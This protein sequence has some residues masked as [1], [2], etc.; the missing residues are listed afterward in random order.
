MLYD[1]GA[2]EVHSLAAPP[3]GPLYA[4]TLATAAPAMDL[5]QILVSQVAQVRSGGLEGQGDAGEAMMQ[6][7]GAAEESA[8]AATNSQLLRIDADGYGFNVWPLERDEV[9]SLLA[10]AGGEVL[11]GT[12]REGRLYR[13]NGAGDISLLLKFEA[14]Q[15]SA[16]HRTAKQRLVLAT[17]N[18]G[19]CYSLDGRGDMGR[20]ESET[21]NAATVA[22]WGALSWRG[23]GKIAFQTRSG[24]TQKPEGTWS[25]WQ[26]L[27]SES[28]VWR[29]ASPAARFLQWRCDLKNGGTQPALEEVTLSYLQKNLPPEIVEL[30]ILPAGDFFDASQDHLSAG[31]GIVEAPS[32]PKRD[33]KKGY[34]TAA[35]QFNDPNRDELLFSLWYRRKADIHWRRLATSLAHTVY[36]W[37]TTQMADGEYQIKV[38]ASDSLALPPGSGLRAEKV[39]EPFLVD[40]TGPAIRD[41]QVKTLGRGR[42][43]VFSVCDAAS[44]VQRVRVSVNAGGWKLLY[45][46]D[47]IC[48]SLCEQFSFSL[49]NGA[50]PLEVT[51]EAADLLANSGTAY[52]QI[53]G[54]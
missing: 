23:T 19:F 30:A 11:V 25:E 43:L 9:Q 7:Q 29:I 3:G 13:I 22:A 34:R 49:E 54:F 32:L 12:G 21:L 28:G 26:T 52:Q 14:T 17:S 39:S 44:P 18:L 38:V 2:E 1:S 37:D 53:K 20:Y 16:L 27:T 6:T 40:N 42:A 48:D 24:N 31:A 5:A 33:Y 46:Q 35:W 15:I 8:P 10:D 36:S 41:I 45:P 4:A 51:I 47:G 50:A